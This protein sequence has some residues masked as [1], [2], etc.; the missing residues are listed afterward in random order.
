MRPHAEDRAGDLGVGETAERVHRRHG[1]RLRLP[2]VEQLA[3]NFAGLLVRPER[4]GTNRFHAAV[5]R[6]VGI[7]GDSFRVVE[8]L[9]QRA[10]QH[11]IVTRQKCPAKGALQTVQ[12]PK[13]GS[14]DGIHQR[15]LFG[16]ELLQSLG[17]LIHLFAASVQTHLLGKLFQQ[18]PTA[19]GDSPLRV[20]G[21]TGEQ[22]ARTAHRRAEHGQ[23]DPPIGC[24]VGGQCG[25]CGRRLFVRDLAQCEGQ[26][27]TDGQ[28]RVVDQGVEFLPHGR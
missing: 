8:H 18:S 17:H 7:E 14:H 9:G 3:Q 28:F 23:A 22:V 19:G 4:Q 16:R 27:V 15:F 13:K 25:Q 5:G 26:L 21:E 11:R 1:D 20:G 2:A 24:I 6:L 10:R 12:A